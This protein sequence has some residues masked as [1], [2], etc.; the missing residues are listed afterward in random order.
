M[1][2]A[3]GAE[4]AAG[5]PNNEPVDAAVACWPKTEV[6]EVVVVDCPNIELDPEGAEEDWPKMELKQER[7]KAVVQ[8]RR[9]QLLLQHSVRTESPSC[10]LAC[11][12]SQKLSWECFQ[13]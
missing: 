1:G 3:A 11:L 10:Q 4:L 13:L 2:A 12:C 6:V 8:T 7:P 5:W 9:L